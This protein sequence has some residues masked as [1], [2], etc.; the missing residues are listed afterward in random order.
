MSC[1]VH[2]KLVNSY[3]CT[4]KGH[5]IIAT[6]NGELLNGNVMDTAAS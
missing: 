6:K 3:Y 2:Y 4:K 1:G 5:N